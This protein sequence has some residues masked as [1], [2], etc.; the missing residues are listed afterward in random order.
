MLT[1]TAATSRGGQDGLETVRT[2]QNLR[3]F[4]RLVGDVIRTHHFS[5]FVSSRSAPPIY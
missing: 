3:T 2:K 4:L 5:G 1:N